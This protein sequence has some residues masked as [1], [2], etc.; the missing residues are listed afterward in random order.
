MG[1]SKG[2]HTYPLYAIGFIEKNDDVGIVPAV[3]V[4]NLKVPEIIS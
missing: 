2:F 4:V 1:K 3:D